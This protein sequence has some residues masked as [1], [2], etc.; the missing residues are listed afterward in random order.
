VPRGSLL[1]R[2]WFGNDDAWQRLK[3]AVETPSEEGFLAG[4][5]FVDDR[6]CGGLDA[7]TLK[8]MTPQG[9]GAIV[10]FIADE[11]TLTTESWSILVVRVLPPQPG[12]KSEEH[13]PFRVIAS[14]LWS[15]ENNLNLANTFW[16]V[17]AARPAPMECSGVSA[18]D[19]AR[20]S[21]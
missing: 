3:A 2:T 13:R 10:S 1:V 7:E 18:I 16:S 4:V 12:G 17:F 14:E 8:A 6:A 21:G 11:V 15:V 5:K 9:Y 20:A 19:L